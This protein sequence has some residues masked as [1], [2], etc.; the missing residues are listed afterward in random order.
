M[1][2]DEQ[3]GRQALQA[4]Q[5]RYLQE[6]DLAQSYGR[7]KPDLS[8]HTEVEVVEMRPSQSRPELGVVKVRLTTFNQADQPVQICFP[9]LMI[10]RRG[11]R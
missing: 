2:H 3:L 6:L 1:T 5:E 4:A 8:V 11:G 9:V 7:F 10:P